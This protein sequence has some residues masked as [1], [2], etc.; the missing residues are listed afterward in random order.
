M[1]FECETHTGLHITDENVIIEAERITGATCDVSSDMG[2]L[3]LTTLNSFIMPLIRHQNG[4][5]VS[6]ET[7]SCAC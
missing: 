1:A 3:A 7:D 5:I 6:L 4:D 2:F